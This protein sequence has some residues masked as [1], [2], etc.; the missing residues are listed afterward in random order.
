MYGAMMRPAMIS[1]TSVQ[2]LLMKARRHEIH[3]VGGIVSLGC[4]GRQGCQ[5]CQGCRGWQECKGCQGCKGC[6]VPR[7]NCN[8]DL[9]ADEPQYHVI[10]KPGSL[11]V[12]VMPKS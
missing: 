2:A 6:E 1:I 12:A 8:V 10:D 9:F 7:P 11:T 5:G 3:I 4:Q